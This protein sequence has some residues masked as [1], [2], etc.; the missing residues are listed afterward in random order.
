MLVVAATSLT[1]TLGAAG[2]AAVALIDP[3]S[4]ARTALAGEEAGPAY[5]PP[6]HSAD[7]LEVPEEPETGTRTAR[8]TAKE[9]RAARAEVR[10][11]RAAYRA[12]ARAGAGTSTGAAYALPPLPVAPLPPAPDLPELPAQP[13]TPQPA[14]QPGGTSAAPVSF[15]ISSFNVLGSSH[16][17]GRDPRPS[18]TVRIARAAQLLTM[19]GVDVAGLQ[20]LQSDQF[21]ELMRITGDTYDIY[22]GLMAGRLGVDNS[23]IWRS[24]EWQLQHATT[25]PIPYFGGRM[26]PMPYVLLRHATTGRM[27]WV[28]NFHNP[29]TNRKRGNNDHWRDR[30]A[31]IETELAA[32]LYRETGYPVFVVGDMNDRERFFCRFTAGA[33]MHAANGGSNDGTCRPPRYPMPVDWIFGSDNVRFSGYARDVGPL[34]RSTT[35]HPMIRA[36]AHLDGSDGLR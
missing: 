32:R 10:E 35:D 19:H 13:A 23:I 6:P 12:R 26:R 11:R 9:R 25:I 7:P 21:R 2:V 3:S 28:G 31:Q 34:V 27:I 17:A 36:T 30:A 14:A 33:P 4:S 22:P 15:V 24:A 8:P 29:A 20:E 16:T 5:V 1:L 18:G